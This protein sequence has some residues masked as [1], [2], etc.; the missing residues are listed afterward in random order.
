[1]KG[2]INNDIEFQQ[3]VH[4]MPN[5]KKQ[6]SFFSADYPKLNIK[7]PKIWWPWQY[8]KPELNR[9]KFQQ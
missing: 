1:V 3:K 8:G 6:V 5:E 9:L 7:N 4:L 2:K